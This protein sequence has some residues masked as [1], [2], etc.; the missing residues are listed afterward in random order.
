MQSQR[1]VGW[2]EELKGRWK[3]GTGTH[4]ERK[5]IVAYTASRLR[6]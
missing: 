3:E 4:E 1:A 5:V 2:F 6:M